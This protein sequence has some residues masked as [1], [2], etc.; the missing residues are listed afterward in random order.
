M[1]LSL[2]MLGAA[3]QQQQQQSIPDAPAPATTG[4]SDLKNQVTPGSGATADTKQGDQNAQQNA[5]QNQSSGQNS[6][7][8]QTPQPNQQDATPQQPPPQTFGNQQDQSAFLIRV[9]VNYIQVPVRVWDKHHHQVAGLEP[10]QFRIYE[11]GNPQNLATFSVVPEPLSVAFVIDQ[12]LPSDIMKK[13]NDSLDAITGAFAPYDS[14]AVITYNT[15]PELVTTFTGMRGAR[16][17]AA[18]QS[19]KRPGRDMGMPTVSGPMASGMSINGNSPDPNLAPQ[20]GNMSGFLVAPKES[21][22]LNDAILF[23][24]RELARQPHDRRRVIYVIGDGKDQRSK[25]TQKEVLKFLLTNNISVYGTLVG[26][27]ATWGVG[28]LDKLRLP[29]LPT[30]N[31]LPKYATF[32]GGYLNAQ[33]SENGIQRSFADIAASLRSD[34][35]LGYYSHAPSLSEKHHSIEVKVKVPDVD[36]SAKEG[37]YPSLANVSQ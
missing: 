20:R 4:L 5:P 22:P 1:A 35:T 33:F 16:L 28:Y 30:D 34:Y 25:V 2:F 3:Q 27:S 29:L 12:T 37:Y 10:E 8:S 24:A 6:N 19:A 18:L 23:A 17:P 31:V 9:P 36:V 26:D 11:D 13:V 15:S 21:H 32:T 7:S 14:M